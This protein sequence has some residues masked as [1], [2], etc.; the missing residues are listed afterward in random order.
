MCVLSWCSLSMVNDH[1]QVINCL[2]YFVTVHFLAN[3]AHNNVICLCLCELCIMYTLAYTVYTVSL[4][5]THSTW[6][7]LAL[8]HQS[9]I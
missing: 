6:L 8:P 1:S 7:F 2:I 9:G 3:E 5:H 4:I